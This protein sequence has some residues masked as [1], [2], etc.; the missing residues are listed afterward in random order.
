VLVGNLK[1]GSPAPS[2]STP[3]DH[4]PGST[5]SEVQRFH[6]WFKK[7]EELISPLATGR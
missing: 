3:G 1:P 2:R 6:F 5:P 7:L 4:F